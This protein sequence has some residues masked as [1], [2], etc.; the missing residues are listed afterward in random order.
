MAKANAKRMKWP[1]RLM[2]SC[3][4]AKATTSEIAVITL[5]NARRICGWT[6]SSSAAKTT[7]DGVGIVS[8]CGDE[9]GGRRV[10]GGANVRVRDS[11]SG[12]VFEQFQCQVSGCGQVCL[13]DFAP[14]VSLV[15]G[16]TWRVT[17]V[18]RA[19]DGGWVTV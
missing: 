2:V 8:V 6:S 10:C 4:W 16:A 13:L 15:A 17:V 19:D 7:T 14:W 9:T 3:A 5:D 1:M 12:A 11:R 18:A